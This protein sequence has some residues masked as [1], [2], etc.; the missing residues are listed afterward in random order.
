MTPDLEQRLRSL[1]AQEAATV[2]RP[3]PWPDSAAEYSAPG[4]HP[5]VI[6]G[7]PV[8]GREPALAGWPADPGQRPSGRWRHL[9][10]VLAAVAVIAI[11]GTVAATTL[12]PTIDDVAVADP[13]TDADREETVDP[14]ALLTATVDASGGII[15]G[16]TAGG[17]ADGT[18]ASTVDIYEDALCPSCWEFEARHH[19]AIA[20]GVRDGTFVV[21]Y[22]LLN[23]L[24]GTSRS[25]DYSTRAC[26]ALLSVARIDGARPGVFPAFHQQLFAARHHPSGSPGELTDQQL[27]DLAKA[28]GASAAA[29]QAIVD[30]DDYQA[31]LDTA[32]GNYR[33]LDRLHRLSDRRMGTPAVVA[34]EGLV[35]PHDGAWLERALTPPR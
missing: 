7:T 12:R 33:E 26:A 5:A 21:R 22:R 34:G 23:I 35:D 17:S 3:A 27:A 16:V 29:Q 24:D 31:A 10:P 20:E 25:G 13:G 4:D 18:A 2:T 19:W 11:V 6:A 30:R 28:A 1:F 9:V 14:A 8:N 32:D 15:L